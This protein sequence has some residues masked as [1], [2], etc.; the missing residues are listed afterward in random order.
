MLAIEEAHKHD[1]TDSLLLGESNQI[2]GASAANIFWERKGI[3]FTPELG[4]GVL[5]GVMR[6]RI[7]EI[8]PFPVKQ[9]RYFMN[10][11]LQADAVILTN[12]IRKIQPV[13]HLMPYEH[14]FNS[15]KLAER[16]NAIIKSDISS[17][18][19]NHE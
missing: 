8:S 5:D 12:S 15:M 13:N 10:D 16:L 6:R 17:H 2:C 4:C 9:G 1:C 19:K 7:I 14:H 11:L 3:L 18:T